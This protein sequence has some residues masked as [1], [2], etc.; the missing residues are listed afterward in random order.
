MQTKEVSMAQL[1]QAVAQLFRVYG[2]S[3]RTIE[4]SKTA[5]E[6]EGYESTE[7]ILPGLSVL[8]MR[9]RFDNNRPI[10]KGMCLGV[11][12]KAKAPSPRSPENTL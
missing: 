11:K 1:E 3:L 12:E 6:Q 5:N 4:D 9:L 7:I 2:Q 8:G 10:S